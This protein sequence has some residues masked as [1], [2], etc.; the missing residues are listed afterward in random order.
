MNSTHCVVLTLLD[1]LDML[2]FRGGVSV[3]AKREQY[4]VVSNDMACA[5]E[6][7][8]RRGPFFNNL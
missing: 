1:F 2:Y 4:Y 5:C 6:A 7:Y 3:E 8:R